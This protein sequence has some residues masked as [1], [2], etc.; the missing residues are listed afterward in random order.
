MRDWQL[1][2]HQIDYT[3]LQKW[4]EMSIDDLH[5]EKD[6]LESKMKILPESSVFVRD[7]MNKVMKALETVIDYR[8]T[9]KE[10]E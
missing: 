1:D 2:F 3:L 4:S 8:E 9:Q 10:S 7:S 6:V 5:K